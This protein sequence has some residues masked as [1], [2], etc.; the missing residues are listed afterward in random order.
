M[1]IE[2]RQFAVEDGC[3]AME[4]VVYRDG[5]E[6]V[7]GYIVFSETGAPVRLCS[8]KEEARAVLKDVAAAARKKRI[9]TTFP[10]NQGDDDSP[11]PSM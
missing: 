9:Q 7:T 3:T 10:T 11:H 8:T 5:R 4:S 1:S 2:L 6:V